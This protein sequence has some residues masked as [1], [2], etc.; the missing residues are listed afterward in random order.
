MSLLC[1]GLSPNITGSLDQFPIS[2]WYG[3][4]Q[5][6]MWLGAFY[7]YRKGTRASAGTVLVACGYDFSAQKSS[8]LYG[9]ASSVQPPALQILMIIKV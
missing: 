7:R 6:D 1:W 2:G 9:S 4:E 5:E 3:K 8:S